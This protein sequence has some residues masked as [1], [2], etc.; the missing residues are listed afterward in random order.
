MLYSRR[1]G[2]WL[3]RRKLRH[4]GQG[5]E[6]RPHC[7]LVET[8]HISI[9]ARVV[10]RPGCMFFAVPDIAE[11]GS[12]TIQ[13]HVLIGSG[14]HIYVSNH[15]FGDRDRLIIDQGHE[16]PRPVLVREG[17]WIG[18]CAILLPGVVV[19]RNAV[20]AAGS[21]VTRSVDDFDVV[22]GAPARSI[23]SGRKA[24]TLHA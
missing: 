16:P 11:Q 5:A 12:I 15:A 13:D 10:I 21:V 1:L 7:H 19:G 2:R 20:V 23:G 24:P 4:I 14:V 9:G 22:A 18:A 3:V 8:R 6:I 17:A